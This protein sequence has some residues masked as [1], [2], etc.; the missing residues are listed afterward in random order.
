MKSSDTV[1][2]VRSPSTDHGTFGWLVFG[3]QKVRTVELPWRDNRKR[4]S[5][6]PLG[7][8]DVA[9]VNSPRF[10]RVYSVLNVPDRSNILFHAANLGGDIEAGWVTQLQGCIAP[11]LRIGQMQ[12]EDGR[13]QNAGLISRPALRQLM[14]WTRDRPFNLEITWAF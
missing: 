2:L 6:I 13:W 4:L 5:C 12:L 14:G 9:I 10:G 8:Y 3:G 1:R 11:C 7:T